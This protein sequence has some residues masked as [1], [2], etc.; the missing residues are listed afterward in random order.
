MCAG[1]LK[2]GWPMPRLMMSRPW[3][4]SEFARASTA[5]AFSSPMRSKFATVRSIGVFLDLVIPGPAEGRRPESITTGRAKLHVS[6]LWAP[7]RAPFGRLAG[8]TGVGSAL[9]LVIQPGDLHLGHA[10]HLEDDR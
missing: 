9:V 8:M 7:A 5:K 2:S 1:V 4:A 3:A 6:R 10:H